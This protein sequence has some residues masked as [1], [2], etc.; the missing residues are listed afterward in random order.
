VRLFEIRAAPFLGLLYAILFP[1]GLSLL[2]N[3]L[4]SRTTAHKQLKDGLDGAFDISTRLLLASLHLFQADRKANDPRTHNLRVTVC[5]LRNQLASKSSALPSIYEEATYEIAFSTHSIVSCKPFVQLVQ[6]LEIILCSRTGLCISDGE[7]FTSYA[8]L[9]PNL[10]MLTDALG[11]S[12]LEALTYIRQASG[13]R[14]AICK[15]GSDTN[16]EKEQLDPSKLVTA[17]ET[18]A[19]TLRLSTRDALNRTIKKYQYDEGSAEEKWIFRPDTYRDSF[20]I[21]SLLEVGSKFTKVYILAQNLLQLSVD[22]V[23]CTLCAADLAALANGGKKRLWLPS[24]RL[25]SSLQAREHTCILL[26]T[27]TSR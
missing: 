22:I 6:K 11:T 20:F 12:M 19:V 23:K 24:V 1:A 9:P 16:K 18:A 13:G 7:I 17:T 26:R 2:V 4:V 14:K 21:T 8:H 5:D 15:K 10:R 3:I 27:L 25:D